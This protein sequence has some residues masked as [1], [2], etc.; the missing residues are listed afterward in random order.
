[1]KWLLLFTLASLMFVGGYFSSTF[2]NKK[3]PKTATVKESATDYSFLARRIFVENPNDVILNFTN[4]NTVLEEYIDNAPNL[5]GLYFEYLPTGTK[6]G[7]NDHDPFFAASLLKIPLA[8]EVMK[9][10]ENKTIS[11]E[12]TLTL[13]NDHLDKDYGELWKKGEGY[14]LTVLDALKEMIINSDNTA[15]YALRDELPDKDLAEI[16]SYLDIPREM[17]DH[18]GGVTPENYSS[19]LKSL[20]FSSYLSFENSNRLLTI[21]SIPTKIDLLSRNLP[22]DTKIANKVGVYNPTGDK[23]SH[24]LSD[25]GIVYL[26]NRQYV[27]CIMTKGADN[28]TGSRQIATLSK[29]VHDYLRQ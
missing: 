10:V 21:M 14:K 5:I 8:M 11:L 9:Q 15:Y 24:V 20:Y 22:K 25:C 17:T 13:Q 2:Y 12:T 1:M 19:I 29:V 23:S 6:V 7:I 4:L 28:A 3:P 18:G 26:P 27:L 16:F